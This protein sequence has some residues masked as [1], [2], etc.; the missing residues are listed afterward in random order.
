VKGFTD[1]A[2]PYVVPDERT[3]DGAPIMEGHFCP[4]LTKWEYAVIE[5]AKGLAACPNFSHIPKLYASRAVEIADAVMAE[6]EKRKT[7]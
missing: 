2:F 5:I 1:T 3:A 6:F 4:G 7:T